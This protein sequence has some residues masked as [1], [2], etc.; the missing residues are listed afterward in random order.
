M[1]LRP[2]MGDDIA[3][4]PARRPARRRPFRWRELG[5]EV[6]D[7]IPLATERCDMVGHPRD[8]ATCANLWHRSAESARFASS[9][10]RRSTGTPWPRSER[11]HTAATT[12]LARC[13]YPPSAAAPTEWRAKMLSSCRRSAGST[14]PRQPDRSR[15]PADLIFP[16]RYCRVSPY[17]ETLTVFSNSRVTRRGTSGSKECA[18][19][20]AVHATDGRQPTAGKSSVSTSAVVVTG[21]ACPQSHPAA[22]APQRSFDTTQGSYDQ[23][24]DT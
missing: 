4:P 17:R 24:Q 5:A 3:Y 7:G 10:T 9:P 23:P 15:R 11:K 2:E 21:C 19:P 13:R 18:R 20:G 6:Q 8:A 12:D 1:A 22:S 16:R 14:G